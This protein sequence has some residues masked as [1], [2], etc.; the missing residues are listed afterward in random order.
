MQYLSGR[1]Q[2]CSKML[3]SLPEPR[4]PL[5]VRL[6]ITAFARESLESAPTAYQPRRRPLIRR[7]NLPASTRP[8]LPRPSTSSWGLPSVAPA[9]VSPVRASVR[10]PAASST[11][12]S[13]PG[14]R[15]GPGPQPCRKLHGAKRPSARSGPVSP[16]S[17]PGRLRGRC[18]GRRRVRAGADGRSGPGP[19]FRRPVSR[20]PGPGPCRKLHGAIEAR[21]ACQVRGRGGVE[22]P[23]AGRFRCR[24]H[25][26]RRVRA[27]LPWTGLPGPQAPKRR[28]RSGSPWTACQAVFD[29]RS[30]RTPR[31]GGIR[32]PVFGPKVG[33]KAGSD[34]TFHAIKSALSQVRENVDVSRAGKNHYVNFLTP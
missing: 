13:K 29:G 4:R 18:R 33:W 1:H 22:A 28:R 9:I 26:R 25:R 10:V 7:R 34:P 3:E 31:R 6:S 8:R 19:R 21:A 2:A 30:P 24:G 15:S 11:A 14:T 23:C 12:P 27:G 16:D 5:C 32:T 17:P 20:L